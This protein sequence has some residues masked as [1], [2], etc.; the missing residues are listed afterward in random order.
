MRE[1]LTQ[2]P[3]GSKVRFNGARE[4]EAK[5]NY[6]NKKKLRWRGG[7]GI[8]HCKKVRGAGEK[9]D[10]EQGFRPVVLSEKRVTL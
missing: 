4:I 9:R 6:S 2:K 7:W 10:G 1:C 8:K 5:F 3:V